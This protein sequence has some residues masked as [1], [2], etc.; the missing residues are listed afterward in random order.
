MAIDDG[1]TVEIIGNKLSEKTQLLMNDFSNFWLNQKWKFVD[2]KKSL[3]YFSKRYFFEKL[4]QSKQFL[5][6]YEVGKSA[7]I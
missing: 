7:K 3:E 1:L 4:N 5:G 6:F 2:I